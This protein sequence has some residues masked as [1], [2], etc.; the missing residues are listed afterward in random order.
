[1]KYKTTLELEIAVMKK[2][3][4]RKKLIVTN[5]SWGLNIHEC[6]LL[7]VSGSGYATEIEIKISKSDLIKDLEKR[8]KHQNRK[9]KYLYFA[10][11]SSLAKHIEYVPTHAGIMVVN[12]RGRVFT[13]ARP[14]INPA[15]R[16]L[17]EDE[18]FQVAKLGAMR[19][20]GLKTK[21]LKFKNKEEIL[22]NKNSQ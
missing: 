1:V 6:D 12:S 15:C 2:L 16:P 18:I 11:P 8:H 14:K 19:I 20:L 5:I 9:I 22:K 17:T 3:G 4:I 7:M 10:M 21:I 13:I